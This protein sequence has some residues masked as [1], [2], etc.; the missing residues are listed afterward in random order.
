MDRDALLTDPDAAGRAQCRP[1]LYRGWNPSRPLIAAWLMTNPSDADHEID[2]PTAGR[3]VTIS[4]DHGCG[5]AFLANMWPWRTP[6]PRDLWAALA[7]DRIS[8]AMIDR[9]VAMLEMLG[10]LADVLVVA[11]GA[12]PLRR[13]PDHCRRMLAAFTARTD[14]PLM[15]LGTTADGMPL[16]P[17]ARGKHA[18]RTG[19]KLRPW[20]CV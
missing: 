15:C 8:A 18:I 4:N 17:L 13:F 16:H 5:S 7:A 20:V 14:K 1:M 19:T 9:N 3:V 12:E 10:A 2:D 6:Y 11:F